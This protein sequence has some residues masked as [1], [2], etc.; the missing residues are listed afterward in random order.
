MREPG[1]SLPTCGRWQTDRVDDRIDRLDT[2][3]PIAA[4][5]ALELIQR[6]EVADQWAMPSV[7]QKMSIGALACHLGRQVVR[8][9]DLLA[10]AT[11]LPPLDSVDAH[12]HRAA[13]VT[14]TSPDDPP[15]DR[16]ADDA[17]AALGLAALVA[18]TSEALETVRRLL[19]AGSARDV[20]PIPW[21]GWSLRRGDF[22]LTRMTEIVVHSDD[23]AL[24]MGAETLEVPAE[25]F[26]HVSDLLVLLAFRRHGQ[27]AV[28]ST[29]S[30]SERSLVI[31]A[32]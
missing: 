9:A 30:R 15:N 23:L 16:S 1:R 10:V 32:F 6:P 21:Q 26:A 7:L 5:A 31:S 17:E 4:A 29:L 14:S 19:A 11:D 18:R 25:V 24:I 13:W 3:F 28:I 2:A 12:Y 27:S 22:L 20:V 8:A